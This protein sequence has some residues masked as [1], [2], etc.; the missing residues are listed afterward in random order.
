M[1]FM[2]PIC[3]VPVQASSSKEETQPT[4]T[5][6]WNGKEISLTVAPTQD[7][8]SLL[9]EDIQGIAVGYYC[10]TAN[11]LTALQKEQVEFSFSKRTFVEIMS[12]NDTLA[13]EALRQAK[14]DINAIQD[15]MLKEALYA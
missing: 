11:E 5:A 9:P 4:Q 14:G 8:L 3:K 7:I 10:E 15:G 1:Q 12:F 2:Q 13:S 6:L